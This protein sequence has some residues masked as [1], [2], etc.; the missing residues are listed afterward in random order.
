MPSFRPPLGQTTAALVHSAAQSPFVK[1][2]F[3][4]E[5]GEHEHIDGVIEI[6]TNLPNVDEEGKPLHGQEEWHAIPFSGELFTDNFP[7][8][9]NHA[10]TSR[11]SL[12]RIY[13]STTKNRHRVADHPITPRDLLVHL[14]HYQD[15]GSRRLARI[16]RRQW[17]GRGQ[18]RRRSRRHSVKRNMGWT[19]GELGRNASKGLCH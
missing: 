8:A 10:H 19:Y 3:I 11:R 2:T 6:W 17:H 4:A 7:L 15:L 13:P 5:L 14:P 16:G 18:G 9:Q 12:A 1:L